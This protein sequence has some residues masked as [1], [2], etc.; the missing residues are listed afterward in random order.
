MTDIS[1]NTK[2]EGN[3]PSCRQQYAYIHKLEVHVYQ[4]H[5]ILYIKN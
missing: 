4:V 1:F 3:M 5:K 2:K